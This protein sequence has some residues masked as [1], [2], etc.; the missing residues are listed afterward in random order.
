MIHLQAPK[1]QKCINS[2]YYLLFVDNRVLTVIP[3]FK[4]LTTHKSF[5]TP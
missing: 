2:T 1:M 5:L 4:N 3:V